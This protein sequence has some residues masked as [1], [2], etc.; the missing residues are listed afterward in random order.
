MM[1]SA[2]LRN[3]VQRLL[4]KHRQNN[5]QMFVVYSQEEAD[6]V[7]P[8][9]PHDLVVYFRRFAHESYRCPTSPS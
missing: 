2:A 3:Q 1:R 6:R 5:Q 7:L 9:N 4:D 8:E